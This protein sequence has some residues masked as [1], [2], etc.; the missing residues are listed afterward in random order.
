MQFLLYV[1]DYNNNVVKFNNAPMNVNGNIII[2]A[3]FFLG[4]GGECR[5]AIH[6]FQVCLSKIKFTFLINV[7]D[8]WP[9][10][11]PSSSGRAARDGT[12]SSFCPA[13]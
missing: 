6:F 10:A 7:Q 12:C 3:G 5:V 13:A 9:F 1:L 2:E 8:A 11:G 4:N